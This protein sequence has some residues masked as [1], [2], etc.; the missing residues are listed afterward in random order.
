MSFDVVLVRGLGE[1]LPVPDE[2]AVADVLADAGARYTLRAGIDGDHVDREDIGEL[3]AHLAEEKPSHHAGR[4]AG[5]IDA[6]ALLRGAALDPAGGEE[7]GDLVLIHR[8]VRAHVQLR[9]LGGAGD[10]DGDLCLRVV[11]QRLDLQLRIRQVAARLDDL[12]VVDDEA[13]PQRSE[14]ALGHVDGAVRR[15]AL[16]VAGVVDEVHLA[17]DGKLEVRRLHV[18]MVEIEMR[19]HSE[20]GLAARFRLRLDIF[21]FASGRVRPLAG[22]HEDDVGV[23]LQPRQLL[24]G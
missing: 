10:G 16:L 1:A 6:A 11:V 14:R 4:G 15:R 17:L 18:E 21:G 7:E 24:V 23:L 3:L 20:G 2:D 19:I 13:A 8:R 5:E 9:I 22:M 12:R